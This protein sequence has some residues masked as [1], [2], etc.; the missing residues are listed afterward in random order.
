[1]RKPLASAKANQSKPAE[2]IDAED[3]NVLGAPQKA[4]LEKQ[5]RDSRAAFS[6]WETAQART[7]QQLY[8]AIVAWLSSQ[9][10]LATTIRC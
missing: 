3:P 5:Y 2:P 7:D 4:A 1:M 6:N 8:R 9:P 10:P